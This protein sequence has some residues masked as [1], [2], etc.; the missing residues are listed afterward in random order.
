M[1][2]SY[3]GDEGIREIVD[4]LNSQGILSDYRLMEEKKLMKEF[5]TEVYSGKGLA[6]YGLQ[7]VL[8]SL[9]SGIVG[10]L[11]MIDEIPFVKI[12]AKCNRCGNVRNK[13]VERMNLVNTKQLTMSEPCPNCGA[14][15]STISEMDI[16]DELKSCHKGQGQEWK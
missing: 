14:T 1:D 3:S 2:C 11:M 4:K 15:D 7:D 5:M 10:T 16:V 13:Y 6:I 8:K 9:E 12:E